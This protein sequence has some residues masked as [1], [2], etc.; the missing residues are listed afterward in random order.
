[1]KKEPTYTELLLTFLKG[2]FIGL[3]YVLFVYFL[4]ALLGCYTSKK[5]KEQFNK[6][7]LNYP[8]I[9]AEYCADQ[10]PVKDSVI[11]D[12]LRTTDTL[13][14]E[15]LSD[16]VMIQDFDTVR[17][18]IT[19]TLPGK[20]ITNTVTIRD[21]IIRENTAKIAACEIDKSKLINITVGQAA[22][23][24]KYKGKAKTRA[25]IM[26]GLI[27]LLISIIGLNIWLKSRR[28]LQSINK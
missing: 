21:T 17:I 14:V 16:T 26:W 2:F 27:L 20:V 28:G 10:F 18:F 25:Y 3:A 9:P 19:K 1:M 12:T 24:N 6:A 22:E 5:A 15:G 23:I 13:Y 8:E 4:F 11:T 7:A